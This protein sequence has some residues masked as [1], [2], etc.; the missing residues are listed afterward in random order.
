[1]KFKINPK[2]FDKYPDLVEAVVILEGINNSVDGSQVLELLRNEEE[3]KRKEFANQVL[4]DHS[5]IKPWREAFRDFG[6]KPNQYSSSIEALLKRVLK[7]DNLPDINPLVNLY[8]HCS[9]K[10]ILPFGGE[11]FSGVFGDLELKYAEGTEEFIPIT[12]V[13]ND[14]AD[15]GEIVWC[16]DQ[17]IT[18]RKWNWRQCDRTKVTKDTKFGYFIIDGISQATVGEI[19]QAASEF[20][21]LAEK[22]LGAKGR[23]LWLDKTN[24]EVE[25]D[26]KT[27]IKTGEAGKHVRNQTKGNKNKIEKFE[28][29]YRSLPFKDEIED[30][31][32]IKFLKGIV[33]EALNN[34]DFD[35]ELP[36]TQVKIEHPQ[37][38]EHGDFA[39]NIAFILAGRLKRNANEIATEIAK[40]IDNP[41]YIERTEVINGFINFKLSQKF[42]R[43]EI[44]E[45][46]EQKDNYGVGTR[47][48]KR[49]IIEFG[50]PNTHKMPH[51][52]HLFSYTLGESLARIFEFSGFEIFRANYQGDVGP[53]VAKCIWAYIK[54]KPEIPDTYR[55]K[56]ELLQ[57]MYQEGATAYEESKDVKTEIDEINKKIY[58]K[59]PEIYPVYEKTREWSVSYY[60]E[61]EKTLKASYNKY[62][63]ESQ[64]F[65]PGRKIVLDNVG[66]IFKQSEG[67]IIFP[68]SEY[69]LHDRVFITK[70]IPQPMKQ[71][72]WLFN[73]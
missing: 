7:G 41:E 46:L 23:V 62:Y 71:K 9:I 40:H 64:T 50:Q 30:V 66:K 69:T 27:K 34:C 48:N 43:Q 65:N 1:M 28:R 16:D 52:G 49:M 63:F 70:I 5:K 15:V 55:Q 25:V 36:K 14:P 51:I 11:D 13:Q 2:I 24:Q 53:H 59:D 47:K 67:A 10:H 8:N 4:A 21:G 61:F 54:N 38:D 72:I 60:Q 22:Y 68:G 17:G 12:S 33:L 44:K 29:N 32:V 45:I 56:A 39:T 26:I 37:N 18:C 58:L 42:L 31:G 19:K 6:S 57:K 3:E 35:L 20:M 73:L